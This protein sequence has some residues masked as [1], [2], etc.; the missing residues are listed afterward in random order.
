[1]INLKTL[2]LVCLLAPTCANAASVLISPIDPVIESDQNGAS[3]WLENQDSK[4]VYMEIKAVRWEQRNGENGYAKQSDVTV[5]PPFALISPGK[6]Q[7]IRLIKNQA[8]PAGQEQAYRI[9]IDEIP[10]AANEEKK[11]SSA[12][13]NFQMR[14]SIPLFVYGEGLTVAQEYAKAK[15][16]TVAQ[17]ALSYRLTQG[18]SGTLIEVKNDGAVHARLSKLTNASGGVLIEGLVGYVLPHSSAA[19]PLPKGK[20]SGGGALQAIVNGEQDPV[21]L[22]QR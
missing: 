3:L 20:S 14:Y 18:K 13:I 11:A 22:T 8:A 15:G 6:R 10:Q 12:G 2:T 4:P 1:M 9:F 5:S 7:L 17:P 19:F 21:R 16:L